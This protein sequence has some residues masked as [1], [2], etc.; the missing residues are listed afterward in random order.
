M[1]YQRFKKETDGVKG[2]NK[3]SALP[4]NN[5]HISNG[6]HEIPNQRLHFDAPPSHP[7][8]SKPFF[9]EDDIASLHLSG[10]IISVTFTIPY[11]LRTLGDG[12]AWDVKL[13][14]RLDHSIQFDILS[15]LSSSMSSQEHIIIGWTGEISDADAAGRPLNGMSVSHRSQQILE[16]WLA[17]AELATM[18][19]WMTGSR[20][21][22][23]NEDDQAR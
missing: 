16:E 7:K 1:H 21:P 23:S 6:Y 22:F 12:E 10:R 13:S 8:P 5:D 3:H 20:D 15:Y 2:V 17:N 9:D 19:I 14:N 4:D 18:P 11:S